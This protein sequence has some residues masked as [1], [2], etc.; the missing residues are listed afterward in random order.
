VAAPS[1][2]ATTAF[3]REQIEA[4]KAVQ[5]SAPLPKTSFS[6]ADDLR[7]AIAR[8]SARMAH[9]VVRVPRGPTEDVLAAARLWLA[10]SGLDA[11]KVE[12]IARA[13]AALDAPARAPH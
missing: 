1:R 4:A 13:I 7:P 11:A 8:I 5:R 3:F 6:L 10:E 12:S 9:L 2:E